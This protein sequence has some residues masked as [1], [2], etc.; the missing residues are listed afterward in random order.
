MSQTTVR[1]SARKI[2]EQSCGLAGVTERESAGNMQEPS[3]GLEDS[4]EGA[5]GGGSKNH[6]LRAGSAKALPERLIGYRYAPLKNT[7]YKVIFGHGVLYV[8]TNLG[9]T[10]DR[11][12]DT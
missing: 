6:K 9:D 11:S 2:Q 5:W 3:C 8:P 7:Y 10:Y 12:K 4:H 1:E